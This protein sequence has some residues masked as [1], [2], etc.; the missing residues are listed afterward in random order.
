MRQGGKAYFAANLVSQASALARYVVLARILGPRE[1]GLAAVLILT[2][3]F[4]ESISDTGSDR[5]LV[6]DP[7]GDSPTLQGFVQFVLCMRGALIA[8]SLAIAA[9][10]L[11]WF[12]NIPDVGAGSLLALGLA[13]LI[14]GLVHL[15]LRRVQRRSDFRPEGLAMMIS[16]TLSLAATGLAAWIIR[17]HT[18]V[19]YGLVLR[20]LSLVIVSH[21][22]AERP[23]RWA[24]DGAEGRRFAAFAA[25]LAAN[26][27][28]LFIGSQGDRLVVGGA[29]GPAALGHYSAVLLLVYY[30]TSMLTRFLTGIHLP[31]LAGARPTPDA[32]AAVR[33][34][35]GSRTLW[36]TCGIVLGFALV[37]PIFTPLF[38]GRR[39]VE[40]LQVFALLGVL[41]AARFM[42]FWPTTLAVAVGRSTIV[43]LNNVARMVALPL[44][45][46][47][48]LQWRSLEAIVMAFIAGEV[49]ALLAALVLLARDKAVR[50]AREL[51]RV[52]VF[53]LTGTGALGAA[54]AL[55]TGH[56]AVATGCLA[57][58]AMMA[59]SLVLFERPALDEVARLVRRR[60]NRPATTG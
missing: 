15:D 39:F 34:R 60:A 20:S 16:E 18:A 45:L 22:T 41:Q 52:G 51:A 11:S 59:G 38:Y 40:P 21:I 32:F 27:I 37:A 7:D 46:L 35:L 14:G 26:G 10:V 44:A 25:P 58:C 29:L 55:Q 33:D 23:Y 36:L 30:P 12:P 5:F 56:I 42:R 54:W 19:I 57:L 9:L 31:Q 2:A 43:M 1:L 6:Q 4:L 24:F 28:L 3:Q 53:A 49:L 13:P 47:A 8:G 48:I 17:D 50:L